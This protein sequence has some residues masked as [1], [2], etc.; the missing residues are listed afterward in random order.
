[1]TLKSTPANLN[2]VKSAL[3]GVAIGDALGVPVEFNGRMLLKNDPVVDF[4]D[5]G[6]YVVPAG[7]WSDDSSLS[8]CLAEALTL[9]YDLQNIAKNFVKWSNENF[10]TANGEVFD[11]GIT[12]KNAIHRLYLGENPELTGEQD[13]NSNGNG[14]L[15]RVLPLVFYMHDKTID[16]RFLVTEEVSGITHRHIRSVIAC[17]YYLEFALLILSGKDKYQAYN[18]LKTSIPEFLKK[19][20]IDQTEIEKFSRILFSDIS[21]CEIDDIASS[22]YV[23]H[24]LEAS[25]YCILT[26]N[27]FSEAVLKAVNLGH[28][29]DTT[30]AVTGG[31][32]GLIYGIENIP[33]HW[34]KEI[35][36][37]R[38]IADL[39]ER[40]ARKISD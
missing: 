7:T 37:S 35:A 15:M 12:T 1:M 26:T 13:E 18:E 34:V 14:S 10:W 39:A 32:A 22:G 17:F 5:Y 36:R 8:F 9:G 28:D 31:L 16:E 38:D 21:K 11:I 4:R 30:G 33:V 19:K 24:T 6:T 23:I 20:N 27:S 40:L 2:Q 25:M 3:F 29:T